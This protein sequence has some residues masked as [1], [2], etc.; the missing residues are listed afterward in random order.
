M[1]E[2]SGS[3]V[4]TEFEQLRDQLRVFAAEREWD[5]FHSPK[6]LAMALCVEASEL[7]EKFQWLSEDQS[8]N[9]PPELLAAA[10]EEA[11][12]VLLYLIR[13]GDKLGI[14]LIA[15]ARNKLERNA[16]KYPIDKAR[17]NSRKYTEL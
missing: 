11:A 1:N 7:L 5:Q 15:A 14:D 12:D 13:L 9:L 6:N 2:K 10:G 4:M 3:M 8:R 17:G 16:Q